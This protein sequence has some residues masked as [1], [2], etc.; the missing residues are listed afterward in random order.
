MNLITRLS[1]TS[2]TMP[3]LIRPMHRCVRNKTVY[4]MLGLSAALCM[5]RLVH[6]Q[7][8]PPPQPSQSTVEQCAYVKSLDPTQLAP[9][10]AFLLI[11]GEKPDI[12]AMMKDPQI[13][14]VMRDVAQQERLR[15]CLLYT[16]DAADE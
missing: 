14:D 1:R 13:A 11:P 8:A 5:Q 2:W 9:L 6:A 12:A 4:W 10:S 15:S 3:L 7:S 16:S